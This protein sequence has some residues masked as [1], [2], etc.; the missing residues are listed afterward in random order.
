MPTR[1][2]L[3]RAESKARTRSALVDAG[4]RVF[5]ERG[6]HGA[7]LE[8]VADAAGFSTGAVY[9]A[10]DGKSDLFLAVLDARVAD[11]ARQLARAGASAASAAEQGADLAREFTAVSKQERNWSLLVIEFWVHAARDPELRRRFARR[12]DALK[13]AIGQVFDQMLAR[14]GERLSLDSDQLAMAAIALGNGLTL[15]RLANPDGVP[16]ELFPTLGALIMGG[17]AGTAHEGGGT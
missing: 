1:T 15:E 2:R 16:D 13:A 17:L 11:R 12:H 9:S 8:A 6:Y 10:F 5:L 7:T 14:T 4:R 3:T